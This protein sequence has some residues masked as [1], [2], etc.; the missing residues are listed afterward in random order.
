MNRLERARLD[1]KL[2][3]PYVK[4]LRRKAQLPNGNSLC[5]TGEKDG[6]FQLP[7]EIEEGGLVEPYMP[8]GQDSEIVLFED[9][10]A[11]VRRELREE[12]EADASYYS[13][14]DKI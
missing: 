14:G 9:P 11:K 6:H 12:T 8:E 10:L 1:L 5:Y 2:I 4:S 3:L 13:N 7:P